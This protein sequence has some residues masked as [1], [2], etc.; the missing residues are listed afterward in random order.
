MPV[1]DG[2]EHFLITK[3]NLDEGDTVTPGGAFTKSKDQPDVTLIDRLPPDATIGPILT[4]LA[5]EFESFHGLDLLIPDL[6][7]V[8]QTVWITARFDKRAFLQA[9]RPRWDCEKKT[10][11]SKESLRTS[12]S[13]AQSIPVHAG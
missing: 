5:L 7:D 13:C 8:R 6:R 2:N 1:S 12:S 10:H 3:L 11:K 4:F 9:K